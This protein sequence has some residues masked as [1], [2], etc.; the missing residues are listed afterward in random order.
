[1][2]NCTFAGRLGRDAET[3][4]TSGGNSVTSFALA[5]DEYAGKGERRTLWIDCAMW[6][7]R[8]DKLAGYLTKGTAV[9]VSGQAGIRTYESNGETRAS[10]TLRVQDVTL[11]GNKQDGHSGSQGRQQSRAAPA[12]RDIPQ[13]TAGA[14]PVEFTDDLDGD[15]PF[16]TRYGVY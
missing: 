10:L 2:N 7:E 12:K 16:A 11:L 4:H 6:G 14:G 1:M 9:A 13:D 3:R 15:I 5:V 8:G